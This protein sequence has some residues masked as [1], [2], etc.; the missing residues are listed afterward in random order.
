MRYEP[1]AKALGVGFRRCMRIANQEREGKV[2]PI[3]FGQV[4]LCAAVTI[5]VTACGGQ[6]VKEPPA[7]T[8]APTMQAPVAAKPKPVQAATAPAPKPAVNPLADP[9]SMLSKRSVYYDI[10]TYG[11]KPEYRPIVDAHASYLKDHPGSHNDRRQL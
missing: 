1:S 2:K 4:V 5:L 6:Q 11:V 9:N 3:A 8:P 10:D 7:V